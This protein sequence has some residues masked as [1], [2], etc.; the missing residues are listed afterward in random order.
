MIRLKADLSRRWTIIV[1]CDAAGEGLSRVAKILDL[2]FVDIQRVS[3][4]R[5]IGGFESVSNLLPGETRLRSE[6][7]SG[8]TWKEGQGKD[9]QTPSSTP[10][11]CV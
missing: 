2:G 8:E 5:S 4:Q 1:A 3:R 7:R 11:N 10:P 6:C 9:P